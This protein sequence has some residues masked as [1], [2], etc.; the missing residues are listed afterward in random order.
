MIEM[1]EYVMESARFEIE[2]GNT[3][4]IAIFEEAEAAVNK[5]N[6]NWFKRFISNAKKF[7]K[8][9]L[10][11]VKMLFNKIK[12]FSIKKEVRKTFQNAGHEK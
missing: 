2:N 6:D 10:Q 4:Y 7:V 9:I 12:V 3:E 1:Y 5:E 8:S 11:K